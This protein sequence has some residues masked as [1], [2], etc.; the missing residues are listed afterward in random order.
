VSA[1]GKRDEL[2]AVVG[3]AGGLE[4]AQHHRRRDELVALARQEQRRALD[5]PDRRLAVPLV[6]HKQRQIA[7]ERHDLGDELGQARER[8]FDDERAKLG[9]HSK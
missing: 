3:R 2:L 8:V 9:R 7:Q 4:E 1:L 5:G 6:Q